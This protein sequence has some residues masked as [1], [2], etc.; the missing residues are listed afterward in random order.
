MKPDKGGFPADYVQFLSNIPADCVINACL[1]IQNEWSS[2]KM[3]F[4][5]RKVLK[6]CQTSPN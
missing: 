3:C 5:V 4:G 2:S 1:S 6:R